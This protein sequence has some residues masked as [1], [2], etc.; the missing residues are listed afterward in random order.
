MFAFK[1]QSS[2]LLNSA[3]NRTLMRIGEGGAGVFQL[4]KKGLKLVGRKRF[5]KRMFKLGP[6]CLFHVKFSISLYF[7]L[8]SISAILHVIEQ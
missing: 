6:V 7:E 2:V 8:H 4:K 3:A 1:V 5:G